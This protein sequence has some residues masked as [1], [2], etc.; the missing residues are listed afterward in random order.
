[1]DR[2]TL[3]GILS[4]PKLDASQLRIDKACMYVQVQVD[5][6]PLEEIKCCVNGIP[7]MY[8]A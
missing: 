7:N 1:M 4:E 6:E 2:G 8:A 3:P 5:G